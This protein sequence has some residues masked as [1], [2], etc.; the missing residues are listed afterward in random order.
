MV[1]RESRGGLHPEAVQAVFGVDVRNLP[2]YLG[3]ETP[4]GRYVIY[5]VDQVVNVET[6]DAEARKGCAQ[7]D[8]VSGMEAAAARLASQKKKADVQ[9]NPKAIEKSS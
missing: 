6:V 8:Q 1:T 5:R 2:A 9:I 7:L 4:D 3:L